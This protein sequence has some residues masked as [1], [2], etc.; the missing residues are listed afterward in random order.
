MS[1]LL[2]PWENSQSL[3]PAGQEAGQ[4]PAAVAK[5]TSSVTVGTRTSVVLSVVR[6]L[7]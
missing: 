3:V 7:Y 4:E 2:H 5:G 1:G 6:S